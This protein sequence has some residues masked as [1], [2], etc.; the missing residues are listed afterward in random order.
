[1][2]RNFVL[3]VLVEASHHRYE[4]YGIKVFSQIQS[5]RSI[6]PKS[7]QLELSFL[8]ELQLVSLGFLIGIHP[9]PT[10]YKGR[11]NTNT[12]TNP[13]SNRKRGKKESTVGIPTK[14]IP[15]P[16][17]IYKYPYTLHT[18][19]CIILQSHRILQSWR[20]RQ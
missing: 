9:I 18:N 17:T 16:S 15:Y 6:S 20:N 1:M 5:Y 19:T 14:H 12:N 2:L 10:T 11:T 4:I 13:S 8:H 7:Y 3:P